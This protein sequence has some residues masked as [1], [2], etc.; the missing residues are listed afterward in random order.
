MAL[1]LDAILWAGVLLAGLVILA[2]V[3]GNLA[4]RFLL[5]ASRN[6]EPEPPAAAEPRAR[7]GDADV[8]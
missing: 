7:K 5:D 1:D 3:L 8:R 4:A 6:G 2:V